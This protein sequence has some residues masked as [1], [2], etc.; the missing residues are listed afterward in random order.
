MQASEAQVSAHMESVRAVV[1]YLGRSNV[2]LNI[3]LFD[4][5]TDPN[6]TAAAPMQLPFR[7]FHLVSSCIA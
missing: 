7:D 3:G 2:I 5:Y 1:D 4:I 6:A